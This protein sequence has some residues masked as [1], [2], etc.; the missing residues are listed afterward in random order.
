MC[1][2]DITFEPFSWVQASYG[3]GEREK[4]M[5]Q[6]ILGNYLVDTGKLT[7]EQ[8]EHALA[9]QDKIRVKLGLIA[10]TEG[11]MTESQAEEVNRLQASLDKRFGDIAVE[12]GYLTEEQVGRLL[13]MQGN[14][15]LVFVQTLVDEGLMTAREVEDAVADYQKKMGYGVSEIEALKSADA[16]RILPLYLT[17]KAADYMDIVG[18]A[19]RTLIRCV[20]RN[21]YIEEAYTVKNAGIAKA[22]VQAVDGEEGLV[23]A[24]A[25]ADGGMVAMASLFAKEK[26]TEVNEDVLDAAGELVNC[27]NG[28]YASALSYVSVHLELKPPVYYPNDTV[29]D[30]DCVCVVPMYI[31]GKKLLFVVSKK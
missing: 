12:K 31:Q 11:L 28:L 17:G 3:E 23:S 13:N 24:F 8:L 2:I 10:V 21:I 29:I 30:G 19:V 15:Y 6:Y 20:D 7:K 1:I 4:V 27:I 25:E 18:L 5:V 22:A 26:F 9:K 16:E 14:E